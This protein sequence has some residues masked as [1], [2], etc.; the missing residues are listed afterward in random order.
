MATF[1]HE[2]L[3]ANETIEKQRLL[4]SH[5]IKEI[6]DKKSGTMLHQACKDGNTKLVKLLLQIGFSAYDPHNEEHESPLHVAV[7]HGHCQIIEIL[8]EDLNPYYIGLDM[9]NL[10]GCTPL[11]LAVSS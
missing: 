3:T 11:T 10:H 6:K 7:K 1:E 5:F 2:L 8:L 4:L 9:G